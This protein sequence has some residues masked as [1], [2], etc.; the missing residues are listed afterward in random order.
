[1]VDLAHPRQ[2]R[3]GALHRLPNPACLAIHVAQPCQES[4]NQATLARL[5]HF[6]RPAPLKTP[7]RGNNLKVHYGIYNRNGI[8]ARCVRGNLALERVGRMAHWL[9][10][11]W[12]AKM[13]VRRRRNYHPCTDYEPSE[14]ALKDYT[15]VHLYDELP[16]AVRAAI[17]D[18]A[19]GMDH[20]SL[21]FLRMQV[22]RLGIDAVVR[23]IN[24]T[25]R[26]AFD[27]QQRFY[28]GQ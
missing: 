21:I 24:S 19:S 26:E 16:A 15:Y 28:S 12:P 13:V 18:S 22:R 27:K 5:V 1:M 4:S 8:S 6:S 10:S 17:R 20:N 25:T 3:R 14:D 23:L 11:Q 2:Q 7:P 9:T